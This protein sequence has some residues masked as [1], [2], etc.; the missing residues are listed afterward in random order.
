MRYQNKGSGN[1]FDDSKWHLYFQ[2]EET[3][4]QFSSGT[5]TL[6]RRPRPQ[7]EPFSYP[8]LDW[9]D[10]KFEDVIGEGNFGQV[11]KAMIKKDGVRMNAAV[12]ML[13]GEDVIFWSTR[14]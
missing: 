4:L 9:A 10:I 14:L 5:L 11:I 2:G 12:K 8:I 1:I 3:I 13:K 6:T 7:T